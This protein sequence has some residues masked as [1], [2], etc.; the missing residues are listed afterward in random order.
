MQHVLRCHR[1]LGL[2]GIALLWSACSAP[3]EPGR[4]PPRSVEVPA[5]LADVEDHE[6]KAGSIEHGAEDTGEPRRGIPECKTGTREDLAEARQAF[7][8]GTQAFAQG[9]LA[10]AQEAFLAAYALSCKLTLLYNVGVVREQLGDY[11]GALEAF[12]AFA[13]AEPAPAQLEEVKRRIDELKK[14]LGH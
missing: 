7:A 11:G 10:R 12:E 2:V 6:A 13:K 1:G 8:A 9:E 4:A 14:R 5:A 3:R